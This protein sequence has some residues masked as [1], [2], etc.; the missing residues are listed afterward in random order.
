MATKK[1][2]VDVWAQIHDCEHL[3]PGSLERRRT[4]SGEQLDR[5]I[6]Q[7]VDLTP[8]TIVLEF[9]QKVSLELAECIGD[10]LTY[11]CQHGLKRNPC[12]SM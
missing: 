5:T 2:N 10:A 4:V 6:W 7:E 8:L 12:A 9:R 11:L 1:A 3:D